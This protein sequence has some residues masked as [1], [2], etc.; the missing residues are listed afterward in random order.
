MKKND[1]QAENLLG[2]KFRE[3]KVCLGGEKAKISRERSRRGDL[4]SRG[5]FIQKLHKACLIKSYRAL[6]R[7]VLAIEP[8]IKDLTRGFLNN[9][10]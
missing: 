4:K 3:R 10:A 1:L 5:A 8:A 6:K 9:E 2:M 7:H